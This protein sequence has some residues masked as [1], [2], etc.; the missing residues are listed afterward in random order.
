MAIVESSNFI[1]DNPFY[2]ST[3]CKKSETEML[4][5]E[6][7][8][9]RIWDACYLVC[10][11]FPEKSTAS[12]RLGFAL[13]FDSLRICL[14]CAKCRAEFSEYLKK[15][16][17][18]PNDLISRNS[19][20]NWVYKVHC[21]VSNRTGKSNLPAL[22]V[23]MKN[24]CGFDSKILPQLEN[25][26]KKPS[27]FQKNNLQMAPKGFVAFP[28]APKGFAALQVPHKGFAALQMAPK[29]FAAL[30]VPHKGFAALP[31]A[32]KLSLT[33]SPKGFA[34]LQM[35]P[36]TPPQLFKA[37]SNL[38]VSK[39]ML[40]LGSNNKF[41]PALNNSAQ[42]V[43]INPVLLVSKNSEH[44]PRNR[45]TLR[46]NILKNIPQNPVRLT[47]INPP[48]RALAN[49]PKILGGSFQH[50][51]PLNKSDNQIVLPLR[52]SNDENRYNNRS[53][54]IFSPRPL[55]T[56][57]P[58]SSLGK[59]LSPLPLSKPM[60]ISTQLSFFK[61]IPFSSSGNVVMQK[62]ELNTQPLENGNPPTAVKRRC[63]CNK[64]R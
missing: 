25:S 22:D 44:T 63:G 1:V 19:I 14:P 28:M 62:T 6:T 40:H 27:I 9:P 7:W 31:M 23:I 54:I 37:N 20:F 58:F 51:T 50:N 8:G 41:P 46:Q 30:Q 43:P 11:G 3:V 59:A 32:P 47:T 4:N 17:L 48:G 33:M 15:N 61:T 53:S 5:P 57:R 45:L 34:A 38:S 56:A 60:P 2:N 26:N 49:N 12:E 29:G 39:N 64:G 52:R 35:A 42:L 36:K 13:F 16:P 10:M 18:T 21:S 55:S 24:Y